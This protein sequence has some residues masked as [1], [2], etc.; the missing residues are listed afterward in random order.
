MKLFSFKLVQIILTQKSA[1]CQILFYEILLDSLEI[2]F[3]K[4]VTYQKYYFY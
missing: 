3:A 1:V 4:N 2:T